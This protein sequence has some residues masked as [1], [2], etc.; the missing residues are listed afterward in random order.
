VISHYRLPEQ[1]LISMIIVLLIIVLPFLDW[2][3]DLI[4]ENQALSYPHSVPAIVCS[5][6]G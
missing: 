5:S 1:I 6:P 3:T 4:L 2:E